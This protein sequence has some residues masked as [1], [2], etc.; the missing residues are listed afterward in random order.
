MS[1]EFGEEWNNPIVEITNNKPQKWNTILEQV[2]IDESF[3][4]IP[5][6]EDEL[7]RNYEYLN[8]ENQTI[9]VKISGYQAP[10]TPEENVYVDDIVIESISDFED[11]DRE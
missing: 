11:S 4:P 5:M 6:S 3:E 1:I 9:E 7:I 10:V 2:T 8:D